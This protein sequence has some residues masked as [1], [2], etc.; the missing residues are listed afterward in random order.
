MLVACTSQS[1]SKVLVQQLNADW[2][3]STKA[4]QDYSNKLQDAFMRCKAL[5]DTMALPPGSLQRL[6]VSERQAINQLLKNMHDYQDTYIDLGRLLSPFFRHWQER[7]EYLSQVSIVV[8][9]GNQLENKDI[10]TE[11]AALQTELKKAD[12]NLAEWTESLQEL[13]SKMEADYT[14]FVQQMAAF[15]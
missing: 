1:N 6:D 11:I 8:K 4:L 9:N 2:E 10:P 15:Q 5:R 3:K 12:S 14:A 7:T 13:Q